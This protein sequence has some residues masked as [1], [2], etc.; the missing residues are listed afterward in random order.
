MMAQW[1]DEQKANARVI[2]STGQQMGMSA[3]DIQVGLMT[4]MQESTLRNLRYGDRDSQGLFQQRP[5]QGWGTVAQVTDP[6]YASRKFFEGLK[7]IKGRETMSLTQAAQRVQRSAYPDAYAKWESDASGLLS[8]LSGSTS[9][10][11]VDARA[12]AVTPQNPSVAPM[13]TAGA[14]GA[15]NAAQGVSAPMQAS[16]SPVGAAAATAPGAE[17][18]YVQPQV[19][20]QA[21]DLSSLMMPELDRTGYE[22]GFSGQLGGATGK[23]ADLIAY[24]R[25]FIGTPYKWGG[26]GPLGFDCSGL[27]Q[28]V[29]KNFGMDLPR[30][31]S[32]QA[33]AGA[34]INVREAKA[35]DLIAW[36]NSSRNGGADHIGIA[37]GN[38][39]VLHA[40]KPGD[41]VKVSNLWDEGR[42]WGVSMGLGG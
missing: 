24:A 37:L 4:A 3:R 25:Q 41:A 7:G 18:A 16:T 34:R 32:A 9:P 33:S 36:D 6:A 22:Q 1:N 8:T 42:A 11:A 5:S 35:G 31:S 27:I 26:T 12:A 20:A 13:G 19:L 39:Q 23:A 21:P 30:V 29:Y 28:Y 40:P 17:A 2:I 14:Q 38:G 10:N 15:Q